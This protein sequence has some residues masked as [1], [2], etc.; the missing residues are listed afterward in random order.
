MSFYDFCQTNGREYLVEQWDTQKNMSLTPCMISY[1]SMKKVWWICDKGHSWDVAV[2]SRVRLDNA[3]PICAGKQVLAGYNDLA[4]KAPEL[5]AE[6][7]PTKNESLTPAMALPCTHRKV[8]RQ[9]AQGHEWEAMVKSR[10]TG[11][12]CPV[13]THRKLVPGVNDLAT[14]HPERA[15]EWDA[16]APLLHRWFFLV[17]T[18]KF[19]GGVR[20]DI[21]GETDLAPVSHRTR[22]NAG[23]PV[24]SGRKVLAGF[25]D[26]QSLEPR[27]ASQ[28]DTERNGSLTPD[29]ISVGSHRNVWWKCDQNHIW[30]AR[31][32][33]RTGR[34]RSGC[35]VCA[36]IS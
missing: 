30:K 35:P 25:N 28:W 29:Q 24:C 15:K 17:A 5:A 19:G 7:H 26:L 3:C 2:N 21:P 23:C 10:V 31:I 36:G 8:W 18:K 14:L 12:G 1:G 33:S 4:T 34:Q 22:E 9:C 20:K 11:C 32:Y 6:W 27:V 13:C 16:T